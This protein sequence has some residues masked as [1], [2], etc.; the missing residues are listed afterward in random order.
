MLLKNLDSWFSMNFTWFL[1]D[2][3]EILVAELENML[4][5]LTIW[6]RHFTMDSSSYTFLPESGRETRS[7]SWRKQVSSCLTII[8]HLVMELFW[9]RI[10]WIRLTIQW[11]FLKNRSHTQYIHYIIYVYNKICTCS[12]FIIYR[13]IFRPSVYINIHIYMFVYIYVS[14]DTLRGYAPMYICT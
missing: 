1:S 2:L 13:K 5:F 3:L 10:K 12:I 14:I 11:F 6:C 9:K 8:F 4:P 7:S